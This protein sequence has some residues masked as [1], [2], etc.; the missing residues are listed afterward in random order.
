M[1]NVNFD[2]E[3]KKEIFTYLDKFSNSSSDLI[4]FVDFEAL[5]REPMKKKINQLLKTD[6]SENN[7]NLNLRRNSDI[8]LKRHLS[9]LNEERIDITQE[10]KLSE[11]LN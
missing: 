8:N 9:E 3:T 10:E 11:N 2:V 4:N 7:I 5:L 1:R 6:E